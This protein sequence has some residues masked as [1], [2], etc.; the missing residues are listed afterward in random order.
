MTPHFRG[1]SSHF[2][3]MNIPQK[4]IYK[5]YQFVL[6]KFANELIQEMSRRIF[7][8]RE[9]FIS[10][11]LRSKIPSNCI[12]RFFT[13]LDGYE[14]KFP[15]GFMLSNNQETISV[16]F[17]QLREKFNINDKFQILYKLCSDLT[18]NLYMTVNYVVSHAAF[19]TSGKPFSIEKIYIDFDTDNP[20]RLDDVEKVVKEFTQHLETYNIEPYIHFS[21]KKGFAVMIWLPFPD[22]EVKK[23]RLYCKALLGQRFWNCKYIDKSVLEPHRVTR[24]PY[25]KHADTGNV[26]MPLDPRDLKPIENFDIENIWNKAVIP[27]RIVEIVNEWHLQEK[28][29]E[30]LRFREL[31]ERFRKEI[32]KPSE[33]KYLPK[34]VQWLLDNGVHEGCRNNAGFIIAC[35]L[36]AKGYDYQDVLDI[37]LA[38]NLKNKPPLPDKEIHYIVKSVFSHDYRPLK[39]ETILHKLSECRDML[40][41]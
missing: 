4:M 1:M 7:I 35:Y 37:L 23:Y 29:E 33:S 9:F 28:I 3:G 31:I 26:V 38:W 16:S 34:I 17:L 39:K 19:T 25:T 2:C 20:D 15:E 22:Y 36:K 40:R 13:W 21:G 27:S 8:G 41:N 5:L 24:L 18:L 32:V 6:G 14:L 30:A 10:S 11:G 12:A